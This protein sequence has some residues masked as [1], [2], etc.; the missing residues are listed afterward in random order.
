[1]AVVAGVKEVRE[2]G[3]VGEGREEDE[4][5]TGDGVMV[6]GEV[7]EAVVGGDLMF[8]EVA[9]EVGDSGVVVVEEVV[10]E[11]VEGVVVEEEAGV[12]RKGW[13]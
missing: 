10:A 4:V 12:G 5:T 13:S 6:E 8:P 11:E 2:V 9:G 3:E 1:M 7:R